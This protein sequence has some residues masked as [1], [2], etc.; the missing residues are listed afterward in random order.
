MPP[1][2]APDVQL[3]NF[4]SYQLELH[5]SLLRLPAIVDCWRGMIPRLTYGK[6]H[7]ESR[8]QATP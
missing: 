3:R 2:L 5:K 7:L 6:N 4:Y 8:G 1:S